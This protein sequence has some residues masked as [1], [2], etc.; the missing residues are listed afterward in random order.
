VSWEVAGFEKRSLVFNA[1]DFE[2]I[3]DLKFG[4]SADSLTDNISS[5]FEWIT[6][7]YKSNE[8]TVTKY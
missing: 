4:V 5:G 8:G 1:S 7:V 2:E 3:H 6:C